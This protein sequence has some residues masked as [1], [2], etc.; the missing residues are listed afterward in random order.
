M[1]TRRRTWQNGDTSFPLMG[2]GVS[3]YGRSLARLRARGRLSQR[4]LARGL[5]LSHTLVVRI[6]AGTRAPASAE[7]VL[8]VARLLGASAEETDELL[9]GAGYWPA[10]FLALGPGE[11]TLRRV[12]EALVR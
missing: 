7:E 12:A 6:E 1:A 8:E 3:T 9:L 5:G 11:A 10:V 4:A 2:A